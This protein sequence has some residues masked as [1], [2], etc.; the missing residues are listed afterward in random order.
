MDFKI[1]PWGT[2]LPLLVRC[3]AKTKGAVLELGCG[4]YS[5][6]VLHAL[7]HDRDLTS[8]ET[9]QE[10]ARRFFHYRSKN[11]KIIIDDSVDLTR[12]YSVALVDQSPAH[13][14]AKAVE[15]LKDNTDLIVCHDSEHRLY[16]LEP[17]LADFKYRVEWKRYAPWT[18][19][20]S[21]TIDLSFLEDLL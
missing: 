19:V 13:E 17:A 21:N 5:T 7:C 9:N 15:A 8:V 1:D 3:V 12:K 18:T 2:H 16:N 20:V 11:H 6:P 4:L 10:W 14:R